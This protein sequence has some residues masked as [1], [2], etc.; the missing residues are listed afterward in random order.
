MYYLDDLVV[1]GV[2]PALDKSRPTQT[3]IQSENSIHDEQFYS[4][5]TG[6]TKKADSPDKPYE[7]FPLYAHSSEIEHDSNKGRLS[8]GFYRGAEELVGATFMCR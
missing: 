6:A 2:R 5:T 3:V 1:N 8:Y 7:E 4:E